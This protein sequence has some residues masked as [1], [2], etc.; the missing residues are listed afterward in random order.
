MVIEFVQVGIFFKRART[1]AELRPQTKRIVLSVLLSRL[2]RDERISR[3]LT[4][5]G[6]RTLHYIPLHSAEDVDEAVCDWITESYLD[7]PI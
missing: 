3:V 2:V 5:S 7:S 1:F 4:V 6:L